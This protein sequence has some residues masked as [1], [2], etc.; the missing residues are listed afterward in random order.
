MNNH[1]S[2]NNRRANVKPPKNI[3]GVRQHD[4]SISIMTYDVDENH[5][6]DNKKDN[7]CFYKNY[8][9]KNLNVENCATKN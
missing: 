3:E 6:L 5:N 4:E 8:L 1:P 7:R 2:N 9:I